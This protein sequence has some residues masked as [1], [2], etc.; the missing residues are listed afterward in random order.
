MN[1]VVV[2][3]QDEQLWT[4]GPGFVGIVAST[5]IHLGAGVTRG[6]TLFLLKFRELLV[7]VEELLLLST[8]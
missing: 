8:L 4:K 7:V 3:I 1:F 2:I 5:R 6:S